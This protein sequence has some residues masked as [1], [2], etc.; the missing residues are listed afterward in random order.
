MPAWSR[1]TIEIVALERKVL[2]SVQ[3]II[4]EKRTKHE[5]RKD[6]SGLTRDGKLHNDVQM[7]LKGKIFERLRDSLVRI[8][9]SNPRY[10]FE[11]LKSSQIRS[12]FIERNG[13]LPQYELAVVNACLSEKLL[14][15][16]KNPFPEFIDSSSRRYGNK[17][18]FLTG[19]FITQNKAA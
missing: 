10:G 8:K 1:V 16:L 7:T 4:V 9:S 18:G 3:W 19:S 11:E 14:I 2:T 6:V 13:D 15:A 17:K 5:A 12:D